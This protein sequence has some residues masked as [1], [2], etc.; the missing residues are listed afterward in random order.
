[1]A[2]SIDSAGKVSAIVK[3]AS[4]Q[5]K[6]LQPNYLA[7]IKVE[8]AKAQASQS[9]AAKSESN[10]KASETAAA[11][12]ESNAAASAT[13]HRVMLLAVQTAAQA[14]IRTMQSIIANSRHR[15]NRRRQQAQIR[16][17]RKQ[18]KRRQAR[19]QLK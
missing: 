16:Q 12:S 18:K 13:K 10:A 17:T 14:K 11:T 9:A 15:A 8:V 19:Q 6:H 3:E 4:I 7:D 2:F 5:E 1:M